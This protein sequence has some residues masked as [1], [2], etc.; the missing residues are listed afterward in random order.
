MTNTLAGYNEVSTNTRLNKAVVEDD[1]A[2][3]VKSYDSRE[4]VLVDEVSAT[5]T[6]IGKAIPGSSLASAVWLIYRVS[7]SGAI[8]TI[9]HA[10][11]NSLYDNIW[12][13][14]ASLSYS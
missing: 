9:S 4:K 11:G 2:L 1:G 5:L 8:T 12:N 3:R 10:D 13:D 7:V 6:Y 14:R